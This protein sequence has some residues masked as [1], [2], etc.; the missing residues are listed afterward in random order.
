M[1]PEKAQKTA[2]IIRDYERNFPRSLF[3]ENQMFENILNKL[4][5]GRWGWLFENTERRD[6]R[7]FIFLIRV[8]LPKLIRKVKKF[9][10]ETGLSV[11]NFTPATFKE[12]C[13][14]LNII[15]YRNAFQ[16]PNLTKDCIGWIAY[17]KKIE[18]F[19]IWIK[20]G[21]SKRGRLETEAHEIG[22]LI[23]QKQQI[24][25]GKK[26][27]SLKFPRTISSPKTDEIFMELEADLLMYWLAC[28]KS[29]VKK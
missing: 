8:S 11:Q 18:R 4:K 3:P 24:M 15:V 25:Q 27:P 16:H 26:I 22:H 29:E 23:A 13:G 1:T 2:Q 20:S 7:T 14:K 19:S 10:K 21:Q 6:P 12:I 28:D 17:S 9:E 5:K